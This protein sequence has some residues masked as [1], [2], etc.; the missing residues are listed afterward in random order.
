MLTLG[1]RTEEYMATAA[2]ISGR[3]G[4]PAGIAGTQPIGRQ[5]LLDR[6][7]FRRVVA[8]EAFLGFARTD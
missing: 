3:F 5:C 4:F 7:R 1:L 6:L 8:C 2:E